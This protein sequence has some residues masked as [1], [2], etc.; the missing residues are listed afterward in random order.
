M[1]NGEASS[2]DGCFDRIRLIKDGDVYHTWHHPTL[3]MSRFS[4]YFFCSP[5]TEREFLEGGRFVL[6]TLLSPV[7]RTMPG[8]EQAL[9]YS[10]N[11][12]TCE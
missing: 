8:T 5:L 7:P 12:C 4:V 6:L 1:R 9:K 3:Y 11:K 2:W 10:V